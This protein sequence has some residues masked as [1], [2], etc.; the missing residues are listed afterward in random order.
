MG[1]SGPVRDRQD[2]QHVRRVLSHGVGDG[3]VPHHVPQLARQHRQ[4]HRQAGGGAVA[5]GPV[6]GEF[7][8]YDQEISF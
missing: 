1:V 4:H 5:A 3:G 8:R 2:V 7:L 6:V